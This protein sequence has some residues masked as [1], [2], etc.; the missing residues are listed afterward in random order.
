MNS[1]T[2]ANSWA[3]RF[4]R[5]TK[6]PWLCGLLSLLL[7]PAALGTDAAYTNNANVYFDGLPADTMPRDFNPMI[8]AANFFNNGIFFIANGANYQT[9]NTTNF[10]NNNMMAGLN[11]FWFD[12][13]TSVSPYDTWATSFCNSNTV[14][15][16]YTLKVWATNIVSP[17]T[18]QVESSQLGKIE[19]LGKNVDLSRSTISL[20]QSGAQI[21]GFSP[22][23]GTITNAWSPKTNFAFAMPFPVTPPFQVPPA[24]LKSSFQLPGAVAYANDTGVVNFNRMVQVVFIS[25][26]N[27]AIASNVRFD[28]AF[29][30]GN[31]TVQ[32]NGTYVDPVT[33]LLVNNYLSIVD[34][35]GEITNLQFSGS[36]PINYTIFESQSIFGPPPPTGLPPGIFGNL[37]VTNPFAYSVVQLATTTVST[38]NIA[39]GAITNLPGRIQITAD[40]LNLAL[41]DITGANY[42]SLKAT[43]Q[44]N[45]APLQ[46]VS[47]YAD[48]SLGATNG[49][50]SITNLLSPGVPVWNGT[51]ILWSA[52][53]QNVDVTGTTNS[54]HVLFVDAP[55]LSPSSLAQ[56]QDLILHGTNSVVI[57]DAL[58]IMRTLSIDARNL[59]LTTNGYSNGATSPE[60]EL[61]LGSGNIM[62]PASL[63]NLLNLTNN[64]AISTMNL[65]YF[66]SGALPYATFVNRGRVSN[67]GGAIIDAN[68]FE[69][70]G[71]A[72][73]GVG[74]F[75]LQST[76]TVLT[77]GSI[78]AG[79]DVAITT[80]S[81][82]ASNHTIRAGGSLT[83]R[84][85]NQL[86]DG[87]VNNGNN[88]S[89]AGG[90]LVGLILPIL[91]ASNPPGYGDLLGTTITCSSPSP[92]KQ[93]VN[94]WAGQDRGASVAGYTNNAAVGRLILDGLAVN[95]AFQFQGAGPT[96][97]LYVDYL[98]LHDQATNQDGYGNFTALNINTNVNQ[99]TIYYAQAMMNGYSVAEKMNHKNGERLRWV[100][101]YAGH[102]SSVNITFPDGSNY[103][104]N[105]A[106]RY[107][108]HIDSD[109]DGINNLWD[110]SPFN[111]P[112][113]PTS[114]PAPGPITIM[115]TL[116]N[117]SAPAAPQGQMVANVGNPGSTPA[118]VLTWQT[119]TNAATNYV[120]YKTNLTMIN[121]LSLTNIITPA[122]VTSS[123]VTVSDPVAGPMRAYRVRVDKK[124]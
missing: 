39:N 27:P 2:H 81:L 70:S 100:T 87:G 35:F 76:N 84:V 82:L 36:F 23:V 20:P 79:G 51:L 124:Q 63:P 4:G 3:N 22:L 118:V 123:P 5:L 49:F 96:N 114:L 86:T 56:V 72:S 113:A 52:R 80:G 89:V 59:T 102:F 43:N 97:A 11:G 61:N 47:P 44:F 29:L 104:F 14:D 107:S 24:L 75:N 109:G 68:Y 90:S 105:A 95:S 38:N 108:P 67:L 78:I 19:L 88:W 74:S 110:S 77:H 9:W 73:A 8:D 17:G 119:I 111:E 85:A 15:C 65:T 54:F 1:L 98:E 28:P 30:T 116:I 33:S 58:N 50:L 91:P 94:T 25:Q 42:M 46:I 122:S 41:A 69:N 7:A 120:F 26:P 16:Q 10:V 71:S 31:I 18:L 57:S 101:N 53:W 117:L 66:G 92:N 34:N 115:A 32:F 40:N 21:Y 6:W 48:I 121:W 93:V 60:G 12:R 112:P 103:L 55:S 99:M 13:H 106:L 83:L 64:G 45:G 62:W 37:L